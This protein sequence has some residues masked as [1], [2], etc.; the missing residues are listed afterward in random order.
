MANV[1]AEPAAGEVKKRIPVILD[2][3]IGSDIDDTWALIMM[4]NSP[5][6]DVK[7]VV[8][9]FGFAEYRAKL[10]A[11][12]LETAGRTDIPVGVGV[13]SGGSKD[14]QAEWVKDYD[15]SKYPGT[16]H[17]DGVQA[18]IDVIM[19]SPDPVTLVAI[20]PLPN[21]AEALKREP[22]IAEKA[23][24]IGMHGSVRVGYNGNRKPSAEWNV[25]ADAASCRAVLS[26]PWEV[27]IT[28]LDT[29]GLV[30]IKGDLYKQVLNGETPLARALMENYRIWSGKSKRWQMASS[31]LF[32]CVAVYLA[33]ATDLVEIEEL[34]IRVT[35]K[36][37]T[38]IDPAAKKMRV[39]TRWKDMETFNRL[40]V[41]RV[42]AER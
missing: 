9:D 30:T 4:L 21:V 42:V 29:C 40:M 36:G 19:K 18:M 22:R 14:R 10:L 39:A 27:T 2:T 3:D 35:D 34:G 41:E 6:L 8:G 38:V 13:E 33:F 17:R 37:M 32:D 25:R 28:P 23:R 12:L 31:T 5:E 7:L 26:A 24:F 20:G 11:K 16:V 15:L 1:T